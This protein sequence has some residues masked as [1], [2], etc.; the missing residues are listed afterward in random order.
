MES[1][2]KRLVGICGDVATFTTPSGTE[3]MVS[4]ADIEFVGARLWCAL[5]NGRRYDIIWRN[6]KLSRLLMKTPVHLHCDHINGNSLDN[7]RE[8]LR[9]CTASQNSWNRKRSHGKTLFKGVS[10]RPLL[11][12]NCRWHARISRH[13]KRVM[14]GCFSTALQAALC[15]DAASR[16]IDGEYAALNFPEFSTSDGLGK[17]LN[18]YWH[19]VRELQDF[20]SGVQ[21]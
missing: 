11:H 5:K 12:R 19:K 6:K 3:F 14:V 17:K 16:Q 7:R 2:Y 8:N 15:Y 10:Y 4:V 20:V 1:R 13:G 9:N 18:V 21:E